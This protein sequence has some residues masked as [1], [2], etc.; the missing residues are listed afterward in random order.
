MTAD[1]FIQW[2]L[3]PVRNVEE[4]FC[5]ELMVEHGLIHWRGKNIPQESRNYAAEMAQSTKRRELRRFN[6]A[7]RPVLR[8]E[9]V[10]RA[11]PYLTEVRYWSH[12]GSW[13]RKLGDIQALAALT[14]VDQ[15]FLSDVEHAD[16]GPLA[17]M[18]KMKLLQ[19]Q[20]EQPKNTAA[21]GGCAALENL[22]LRCK[23]PWPDRF[24]LEHLPCLRR[25]MWSA[26]IFLLEEIPA[27]PVLEFLSVGE[28]AGFT[29]LPLRNFDKLPEMPNLKYLKFAPCGDLRG[30]ERFPR[31][32][33]L[34]LEG[35]IP[36]LEPLKALKCLTHLKLRLHS[37]VSLQP[38]A[39]LTE[40]RWV[41]IQSDLPFD[42][43][44]L[45]ELPHL[46][47]LYAPRWLPRE[48]G[49]APK[50][51]LDVTTIR[52]LMEP[53][54]R[55]FEHT[56]IP[57]RALPPLKLVCVKGTGPAN[58]PTAYPAAEIP[59]QENVYMQ[60]AQ[61][62]WISRK[63]RAALT[64]LLGRGWDTDIA[65]DLADDEDASEPEEQRMAFN[66][67]PGA[68]IIGPTFGGGWMLRFHRAEDAE[69]LPEIIACI[70][71]VWAVLPM[72]R[73]VL[74]SI[75]LDPEWV[76]K[77][78]YWK[79]SLRQRWEEYQEDH[80]YFEKEREK[81]REYEE[82]V[83]RMKMA[84]EAGLAI[85]P[86]DFTPNPGTHDI[87]QTEADLK[88]EQEEV[89]DNAAN[90]GDGGVAVKEGDPNEQEPDSHPLGDAYDLTGM[91]FFDAFALCD[92]YQMAA[93]I[94]MGEAPEEL[95]LTNKEGEG[96]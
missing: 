52:A 57:P 22:S 26:N 65:E 3:E 47:E 61:E 76:Q 4:L 11:A 1:E 39:A 94:L 85:K 50:P 68:N 48:T 2:A 79:S 51:P 42:F 7:Y 74:I 33:A 82:R 87:W 6:P 84:E 35:F 20:V 44:P 8:R 55:D 19:L 59:A 63:L 36:S 70:R 14:E 58:Y 45:G 73:S 62:T 46:H 29:D 10:E 66:E 13:D 30:L 38:L 71:S 96:T 75:N 40:L 83:L 81:K 18:P 56:L 9:D 24:P 37:P 89:D 54:D 32:Q 69:R 90:D 27:L 25:L 16:L 34:H 23:T 15:V 12:M 49:P 93:T 60:V 53:W 72:N 80:E 91:L 92:S 43:S 41:T 77:P 21:L 88:E 95:D 28:G 78:D 86:E 67:I 64:S 31:L 5:A 17:L